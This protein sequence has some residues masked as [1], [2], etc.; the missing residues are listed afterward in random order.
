MQADTH[1]LSGTCILAEY[2]F[3]TTICALVLTGMHPA[4]MIAIRYGF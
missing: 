4:K 3:A 1:R 2:F